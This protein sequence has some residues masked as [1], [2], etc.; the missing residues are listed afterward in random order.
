MCKVAKSE[1]CQG[2][3]QHREASPDRLLPDPG[4]VPHPGLSQLSPNQGSQGVGKENRLD[5]FQRNEV[6]EEDDNEEKI[7]GDANV[8]RARI[9]ELELDPHLP[10]INV[11]VTT[12]MIMKETK[13]SAK[14]DKD[15]TK[16]T[17]HT[18]VKEEAATA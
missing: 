17:C 10:S 2:G 5:D 14:R 6:V 13:K 11:I 12:T 4:R 3:C 18:M 1:G 8:S 16:L 15:K 7:D 9:T